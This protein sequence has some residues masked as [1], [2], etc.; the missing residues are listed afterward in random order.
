MEISRAGTD[1]PLNAWYA[2]ATADEVGRTPLARRL[3]GHRVV[4]YRTTGGD[5]VVLEDRCAHRPVPLSD[6]RLVGDDI[7]SGYTG[8]GYAPDGR[9]VSVPTQ[10][11]VPFDAAVRS[12][13]VHEDGTF[14]WA[15]GGEPRLSGLRPPPD[16]SWLRSPEWTTFGDAHT[17]RAAVALLRDN[18]ADITHVVQLDPAIAPPV[19]DD[20]PPPPLEV[21]VS[22]TT[23]TFS[24]RF[25][26]SRLAPWHAQVLELP[27]DATHE[28]HEEGAFVSPGLWVD[29]WSVHVSGHGDRD[30]VHT[31]VFTHALTPTSP[32]TTRHIWRVSRNFASSA[33]ATGTLQPMLAGYYDRV[34]GVLEQM[35]SIVEEE[36]PRPEV[37]TTADAAVTQ[38]RRI[39][40][41]LVE[42]ETGR[43]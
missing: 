40:R 42:D 32:R 3:L 4:L 16:T 9:C 25:P 5:A 13:P 29:R 18:F 6:G 38:V 15:W 28:Q 7:F 43:R 33:A 39:V 41:R 2:V 12:F 37:A 26:A 35:Q 22:E 1:V 8:F 11:N 27:E 36:G 20:G 23:V 31:F 21:Q 14:V 19:L 17:T 30:G 10:D 24:R 34:R